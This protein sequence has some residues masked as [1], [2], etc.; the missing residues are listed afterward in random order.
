MIVAS[1]EGA[2]MR[3]PMAVTVM[4]GLSSATILTL[5]IIPMIYYIFG[6]RDTEPEQGTEAP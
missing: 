5:V 6:G 1:G 2:E 4:A 3:R